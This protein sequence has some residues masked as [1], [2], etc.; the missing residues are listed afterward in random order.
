MNALDFLREK[1]I[2]G[3]SSV[4]EVLNFLDKQMVFWTFI[5]IGVASSLFLVLTMILG[6]ASEALHGIFG[7]DISGGEGDADADTGDHGG[8]IHHDSDT[9]AGTPSFFSVRFMLSFLSGF[10]LTGAIATIY[11]ITVVPSSLYGAMV[12]LVFTGVTYAIVWSMASQQASFNVTEQDLIGKEGRVIV[13]IAPGGGMGQVLVQVGEMSIAKIAQSENGEP[14][15][16]NAHVRIVSTVGQVAFV[17]QISHH[18]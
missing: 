11:G 4:L 18:V 12:G 3:I 13:E 16:E 10:G 9:A 6:E 15:P 14:V 5:V 2:Y 8:D 7:H 17:Q 1:L